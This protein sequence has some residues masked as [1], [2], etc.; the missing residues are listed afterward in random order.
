VQ[1]SGKQVKLGYETHGIDMSMPV[2]DALLQLAVE[3]D[4]RSARRETEQ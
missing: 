2:A 1:N 4:R 3:A